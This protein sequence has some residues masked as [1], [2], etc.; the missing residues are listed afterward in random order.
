MLRHIFIIFVFVYFASVPSSPTPHPT[1]SINHKIVHYHDY[2]GITDYFA[3]I[4]LTTIFFFLINCYLLT[5]IC[6]SYS[7]VPYH[8]PINIISKNNQYK[9]E[10][11]DLFFTWIS[12]ILV[13]SMGPS[14]IFLFL[15]NITIIPN[16]SF[17]HVL[18]ASYP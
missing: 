3:K 5:I 17:I 8:I 15:L 10:L 7:Y 13:V 2:T 1:R 11:S 9:I 16:I 18:E 6:N 4:I 12:L 14:E